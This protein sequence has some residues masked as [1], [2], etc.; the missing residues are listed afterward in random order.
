MPK[1]VSQR[2][3]L[4]VNPHQS[5]V[6]SAKQLHVIAD[7]ED[8]QHGRRLQAHIPLCLAQERDYQGQRPAGCFLASSCRPGTPSGYCYGG[9]SCSP[10]RCSYPS[11]PEASTLT[12]LQARHS[13]IFKVEHS[14]SSQA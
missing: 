5:S 10:V 12:T 2:R 13:K 1:A 14:I 4:E 7:S 11:E 8:L 6:G 9:T 3:L